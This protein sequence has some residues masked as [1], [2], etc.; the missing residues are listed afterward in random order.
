[1]NSKPTYTEIPPTSDL[2]YWQ[3]KSNK[4]KLR[5]YVPKDKELHLKLK[6]EAWAKIQARLPVSLR[7]KINYSDTSNMHLRGKS[8]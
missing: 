6:R 3:L 5:T 1:M 4:D 2:D 8:I 7:S